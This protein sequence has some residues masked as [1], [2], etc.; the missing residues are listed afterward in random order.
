MPDSQPAPYVPPATRVL[1]TV[2]GLTL[3][4]GGADIDSGKGVPIPGGGS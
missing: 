4:K 3:S 2:V 1:G